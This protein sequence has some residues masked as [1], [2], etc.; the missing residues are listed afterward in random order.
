MGWMGGAWVTRVRAGG[1]WDEGWVMDGWWTG[2]AGWWMGGQAGGWWMYGG[3]VVGGVV[4]R[5][6]TL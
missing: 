4:Q 3:W 2:A 6:I 1:G 5:V